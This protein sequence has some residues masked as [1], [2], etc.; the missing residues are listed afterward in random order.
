MTP[1]KLETIKPINSATSLIEGNCLSSID[2]AF[3]T[4]FVAFSGVKATVMVTEF[5]TKPRKVITCLS[6]A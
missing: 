4:N 3:V 5:K 1:G 6:V 2:L